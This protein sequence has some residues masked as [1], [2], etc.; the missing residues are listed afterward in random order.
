MRKIDTLKRALL[1]LLACAATACDGPEGQSGRA[2]AAAKAEDAQS[3]HRAL[4]PLPEV[5]VGLK[6]APLPIDRD[7]FR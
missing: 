6:S 5:P 4:E 2:I 1:M 7:P 3:I